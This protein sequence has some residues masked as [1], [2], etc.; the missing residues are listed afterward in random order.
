MYA[1]INLPGSNHFQY[2][3]PS[4]RKDCAAWLEEQKTRHQDEHGGTWTSTYLPARIVSNREA[5]SWKYR[6]GSRVVN[7]HLTGLDKTLASE[8]LQPND[9][10]CVLCGKH[11][12]KP[13]TRKEALD[14]HC[15]REQG[16]R[17]PACL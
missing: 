5:E 15:G 7:P 3:G 16:L 6:D 9:V 17:H 11:P 1:T 14:Y 8:I 10:G 12:A 2:Y 4:T 13:L